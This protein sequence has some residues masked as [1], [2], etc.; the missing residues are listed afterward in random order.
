MA[1]DHYVP[2]VYLKNFY[3]PI[4]GELMY[5]IRKSDLKIFTPNSS[6]VCRNPEGNTTTF[7]NEPRAVEEFLRTIEPNYNK[8][9]RKIELKIIDE[10]VVYTIAGLVAY[11]STCSP[12]AMRTQTTPLKNIIEVTAKVLDANDQLPKPPDLL[13][14][15]S[16]TEMLDSGMIK[17]NLDEKYTQAIGIT[18]IRDLV[19]V[20]G[21]SSWEFL[22]NTFNDSLFL[23]SD[24][25]IALDDSNLTQTVKIIPLSPR[26]AVRITPSKSNYNEF[27]FKNFRYIF[28]KPSRKEI[29]K[30]N[31][32]IIRSA[33]DMVFYQFQHSWVDKLVAKNR[34][35]RIEAFTEEIKVNNGVYLKFGH[36]LSQLKNSAL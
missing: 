23:T 34:R 22:V 12:T 30:I 19:L 8:V 14:F 29:S 33:E 15:N 1:L 20:F 2:Q 26:I 21:N 4:L 5:A 31:T 18:A 10:E 24:H 9:L 32:L 3:S 6:S 17:L 35:Y 11:V 25:P 36:K 27:N 7:L 16:V 28:K 13:K